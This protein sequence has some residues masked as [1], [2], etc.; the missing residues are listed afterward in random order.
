MGNVGQHHQKNRCLTAVNSKLQRAILWSLGAL[1][2]VAVAAALFVALQRIQWEQQYHQVSFALSAATYFALPGEDVAGSILAK[3]V[4]SVVVDAATLAAFKPLKLK[5]LLG[6]AEL[7]GEFNDQQLFALQARGLGLVFALSPLPVLDEPRL[8]VLRAAFDAFHPEGVLFVETLLP[9]PLENVRRVIELLEPRNIWYGTLEFAEPAGLLALFREGHT[10]WVRS[11]LI[12]Y[13]QRLKLSSVFAL[14]RYER[15]VRERGV[16]LLLLNA[17]DDSALLLNEI[18]ALSKRLEQTGFSLGAVPSLPPWSLPG[19][20]V[21]ALSLALLTT[22]LWLFQ[23]LWKKFSWSFWALL[24][25]VAG[26][27]AW[28]VQRGDAGWAF[29]SLSMA[30]ITPMGLY[31]ALV[32]LPQRGGL[33]YG[34][35]VFLWGSAT[36]VLGGMIQAGLLSD[37]AYF[38]KLKDFEGI[39]LALFEPVLV[40]AYWEVKRRGL[41]TWKRLWQRPLTWGDAVLGASIIAGFMVLIL[42]AGNDSPLSVLPFELE[43]RGQL[44]TWLY[45]RPRF[46]EFMVGHPI[47]IVWLAWGITRWKDF[48]ILLA[49]VGFLGQTTM[50]NS[51]AHLHTPLAF[52]LLRVGNGLVLGALAGAL[53][54]S[55]LRWG[56]KR[57]PKNASS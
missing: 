32:A 45:A 42:R 16:R 31:R 39:K 46:K 36:T 21:W 6:F 56:G 33:L 50:L 7:D 13:R 10:D 34:L 12:P 41:G 19:W 1:T 37:P 4:Q 51:F 57:W 29:L 38:L 47:L 44:E 24:I 5:P 23:R 25:A 14:A 54:W 48:G 26:I 52:T 22:T 49:L 11:H 17:K 15:A 18:D 53:F 43:L 55:M 9:W 30:I 35:R 28:Q 40:I 27:V 2:A 20:L 8:A 3:N